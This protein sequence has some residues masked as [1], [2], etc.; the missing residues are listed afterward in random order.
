MLLRLGLKG[1]TAELVKDT[2]YAALASLGASL[3]RLILA[4]PSAL[5]MALTALAASF[6]LALLLP[7]A[8][9]HTPA[10]LR[11]LWQTVRPRLSRLGKTLCRAYGL[12]FLVT[13]L[14][15]LVGLSLL[16]VGFPLL[17]ALGI[18]AVDLLPVLGTG[19]V[20]I[21]WSLLSLAT[22]KRLL[23]L[24]LALLWL[25]LTA[26]RQ[27]LEPR[28]VGTHLGL[29]PITALFSMYAG[30]HLLGAAGILFG[31]LAASA[32]TALLRGDG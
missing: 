2:L 29:S 7:R 16:R 13:F 4:L 26:V 1:E 12:L 20:L 10:W 15:S 3:G 23:A 17:A 28:L 9:E 5:I 6:Y 30:L 14:I 19:A 11:Q 22:G 27:V 21:P 8:E 31:P 24:C 18:A 25:L 32:L